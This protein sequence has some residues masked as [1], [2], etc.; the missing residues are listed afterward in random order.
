[1]TE[2]QH[3][4]AGAGD[5][6]E[7]SDLLPEELD[8]GFVGPYTFPPNQRR[9]IQGVI[10][11]VAGIIGIGLAAVG[12]ADAVLVNGGLAVAGAGLVLFGLNSLA[13][14][15]RLGLDEN[16]ALVVATRAVAMPVGHASAQLGWR[17]LRSRPTWRMLVYSADDPPSRR[18]LVLVDGIDGSVV[19]QL[20]EDNPEDWSG[21]AGDGPTDPNDS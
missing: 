8:R 19:D 12:G 6:G 20:V 14:G 2:D 9:R 13:A 7:M 3:V 21:L 11:I 1:M 4:T 18:A 17:G 16:E 15:A 5:P 10:H